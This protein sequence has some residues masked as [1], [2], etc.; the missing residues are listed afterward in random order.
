MN[1]K[2]KI[3]QEIRK[4][5]D[6]FDRAEHLP[7]N[8]FFYTRVQA[9][10]DEQRRKRSIYSTILKPALLTSLVVINLGTAVWYFGGSGQSD[11]QQ[12]LIEILAGDLNLDENQTN[13]FTIE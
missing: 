4:T 12:E 6:Q 7:A 10:L 1:K 5:L 11:S 2:E 13:L 8:P 9:R 3:E